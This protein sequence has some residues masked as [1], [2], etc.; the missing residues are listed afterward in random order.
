LERSAQSPDLAL[1][2]VLKQNLEVFALLGRF[3]A[4]K[5]LGGQLIAGNQLPIDAA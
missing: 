5:L 4:F 1:F 3:A 2:S